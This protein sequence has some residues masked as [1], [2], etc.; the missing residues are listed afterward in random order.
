MQIKMILVIKGGKMTIEEKIELLNKELNEKI[1]LHQD[2]KNT[3]DSTG[4]DGDKE[5]EN[6]WHKDLLEWIVKRKKELGIEE[7][8]QNK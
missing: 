6:I 4:L 5:E 8:T 2:E 1:S 3:K 7:S